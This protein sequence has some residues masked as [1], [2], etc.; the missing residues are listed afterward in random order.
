MGDVLSEV[1]IRTAKDTPAEAVYLRPDARRNVNE[2][3]RALSPPPREPVSSQ[4]SLEGILRAVDLDR[5][6]LQ[7]V[8]DEGEPVRVL[9]SPNELDDVVGPMVNRRVLARV[10][11]ESRRGR[12]GKT[13]V[14]RRVLDIELLED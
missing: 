9:T 14:E 11:S 1:E 6:W 2:A 3:I 8:P 5:S 4:E 7:I 12:T 10:Q 13:S